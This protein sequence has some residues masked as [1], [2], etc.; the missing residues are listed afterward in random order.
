MI[1]VEATC[2]CG[3]QETVQVT[4]ADLERYR[5]GGHV[6]A[7]WP[8]FTPQQREVI[9]GANLV[10]KPFNAPHT[11]SVCWDEMGDE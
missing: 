5:K 4:E 7:V 8:Q 6:Q 11:C 10:P 1:D 9:I 2:P 3:T